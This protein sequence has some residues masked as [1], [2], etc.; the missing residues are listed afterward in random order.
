M[1]Y[2]RYRTI[3]TWRRAATFLALVLFAVGAAAAARADV[4]GSVL[5]RF[6]PERI[7]HG[8]SIGETLVGGMTEEQATTAVHAALRRPIAVTVE[9]RTHY[10]SSGELGG[11]PLVAE[12]VQQAL[13]APSDAEVPLE[14]LVDRPRLVA[15]AKELARD[16]SRP[17][18]DAKVVLS[19][20]KPKVERGRAGLTIHERALTRALGAA[21]QS[22]DRGPVAAPHTVLEPEVTR[23]QAWP[24]VVIRRDE[25]RLFLYTGADRKP[26]VFGVATGQPSYPTPLGRFTIVS[27][28]LNPWWYPPPSDWAAGLEPVPPGPGN[29]LGTRWMGLSVPAVGIHGTPDAASIGYSASHGCIRMNIADAEWL[30]DRVSEG[31]TV[32]IV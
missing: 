7:E 26:A 8:V 6:G 32:F 5:G 30:F 28:Q 24:V 29:P 21:L 31:T 15:A 16:Y 19:K 14:V 13:T 18:V 9:R 10:V 22:G 17:A 11:V 2:R 3:P 25:N 20:L 4:P 12:A 1:T 27:K 23:A